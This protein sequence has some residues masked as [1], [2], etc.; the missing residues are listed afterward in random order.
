MGNVIQEDILN[1]VKQKP[2]ISTFSMY[3]PLNERKHETLERFIFTSTMT[4]YIVD[5]SL[6]GQ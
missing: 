4:K 6:D 5:F 1:V 2:E 3:N